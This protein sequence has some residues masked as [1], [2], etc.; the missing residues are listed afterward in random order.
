[1][2]SVEN[3]VCV[4]LVKLLMCIQVTMLQWHPHYASTVKAEETQVP[5]ATREATGAQESVD[6]NHRKLAGRSGTSVPA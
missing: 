2:D 3:Q 1:M 4:L 5:P 6:G